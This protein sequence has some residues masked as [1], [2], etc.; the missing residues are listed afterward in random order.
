[1]LEIARDEA[2][3]RGDDPAKVTMKP[4]RLHDLR[5]TMISG[6]ARIG[7]QIA[8]IEKCVNHVSGTFSGIVAVYQNYSFAPEKAAAFDAW[9]V[10]VERIVSGALLVEKTRAVV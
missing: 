10:E 9:A 7:I 1:M 2:V 8:V 3:C 5:H 4:W 6:M